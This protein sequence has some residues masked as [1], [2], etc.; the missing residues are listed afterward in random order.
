MVYGWFT[1]CYSNTAMEHPPFP[2][3]FPIPT[4]IDDFQQ[5]TPSFS[6]EFPIKT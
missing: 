6:D 5:K 4:F 1:L 3:A 2:N